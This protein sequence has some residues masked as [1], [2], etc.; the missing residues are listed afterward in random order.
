MSER[1]HPLRDVA[2]PLLVGIA[3]VGTVV[4]TLITYHGTIKAERDRGRCSSMLEGYATFMAD[5]FTMV[6]DGLDANTLSK[7]EVDSHN[8]QWRFYQLTPFLGSDRDAI[9]KLVNHAVEVAKGKHYP[10]NTDCPSEAAQCIN[11]L[12]DIVLNR[13]KLQCSTALG[14]G[15]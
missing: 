3:S 7:V 12:D 14:L 5:A 6:R 4:V 10:E 2:V 9:S 13:L 15:S 8:V 11:K 1:F